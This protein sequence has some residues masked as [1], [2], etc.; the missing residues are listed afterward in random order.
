MSIKEITSLFASLKKCYKEYLEEG[1]DVTVATTD[2][3]EWD[4]QTGDN[5]YTG[6][7]YGL[8]HWAV[9]TL[10]KE[11]HCGKLAAEVVNEL[12]GYVEESKCYE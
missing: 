12:R 8:R 5:S 7:A 4:Y 1:L 11:S 3:R 6:G 2:G 10:F 9:I